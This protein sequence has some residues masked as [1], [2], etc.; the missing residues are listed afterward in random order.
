MLRGF[1]VLDLTDERGFLCGRILGDLGADVIKVEAPGGDKSRS[2]GP[3]Y[4]TSPHP[5][6]SLYWFAYNANKRGITLNINS[7]EGKDIFCRLAEKADFVL[8]SFG[9][10]YLENI[11]LSYSKLKQ[12]NPR[13]IYTSITPFGQKGQYKHFKASDLICMSMGGLV[14]L[15][16]DVDR[17]PL[18]ISFGQAYLHAGAAA[19]MGTMVAHHY[20]QKSG[21]GQ[22]VD[23]SIQQSVMTTVAHALSFWDI[24]RLN[25]HR[26]GPFRSGISDGGVIRLIWPCKDGSVNF[27]M[28]G[29]PAGAKAMKALIQLMKEEGMDV[30]SIE[31]INWDLLDFGNVSYDIITRCERKLGE[32]FLRHTKKEI[33][34]LAIDR[35]ILCYPLS[36]PKDT[37]ADVQLAARGFWQDVQH[38]E[39]GESIHYPGA[40]VKSLN[41]PLRIKRRAPLVGEHNN[42]VYHKE[43]GLTT[44][45]IKQLIE[46]DII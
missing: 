19:A 46:A 26:Q 16:G 27:G 28:T 18:R 23:I 6:R 3:F 20:R 25:L 45:Q 8:E 36:D 31:T 7:I 13:L 12:L 5:E 1:R 24:N 41:N 14:Y 40:F 35:E 44:G 21:E 38:P 15:C 30:E 32:F 9:P 4:G 10:T 22:H 34:E 39:L 33:F 17:A 29:G 2:M 43:L 42:E 37:L 11:E